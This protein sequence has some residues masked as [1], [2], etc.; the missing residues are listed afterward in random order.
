MLLIIL[1]LLLLKVLSQSYRGTVNAGTYL[2]ISLT[3]TISIAPDPASVHHPND[4]YKHFEVATSKIFLLDSTLRLKMYNRSHPNDF[5]NVLEPF[6][7]STPPSFIPET[8]SVNLEENLLAV[9]ASKGAE[10]KFMFFGVFTRTLGPF[11][12]E[13]APVSMSSPIRIVLNGNF[14]YSHIS[15]GSPANDSIHILDTQNFTTSTFALQC[16]P[17]RSSVSP[18][19]NKLVVWDE[20]SKV[21]IYALLNGTITLHFIDADNVIA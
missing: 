9:A 8:F 4:F 11:L 6:A 20:F 16:S 12:R 15:P 18:D 7:Y 13:T 10:L 19:R 17:C 2:D 14:V 1:N 21:F 5:I 3:K